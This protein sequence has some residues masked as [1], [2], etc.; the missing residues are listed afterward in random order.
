MNKPNSQLDW[1][2]FCFAILCLILPF[3]S[4][5]VCPY[6]N[7]PVTGGGSTGCLWSST[8]IILG[9]LELVALLILLLGAVGMVVRGVK[10]RK[11]YGSSW[12]IW[13]YLFFPVVLVICWG[14]V[15]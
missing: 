13:V 12:R 2:Y 10:I 8:G 6:L 4:A 5:V 3:Y 1:I 7:P 14:W 15:F 11:L 9:F